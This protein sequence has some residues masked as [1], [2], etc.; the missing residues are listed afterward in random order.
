MIILLIVLLFAA[1]VALDVLWDWRRLTKLSSEGK[2]LHE[3]AGKL[4]P[5][6]VAGF[7]LPPWLSYHKGHTW[8]HWASPD[9]A[10][11]GL[12]DFARRLVGAESNVS[13]P[14][15]GTQV[16]QGEGVIHVKRNGGEAWLL[17]PVGG[18]I[19]EVNPYL[20]KKPDFFFRDSYGQ[21]WI[22]KIRSQHLFQELRNL[23]SGTLAQ[24][25]MEDTR[26]RFR[27][28]LML[29]TGSVIQDGGTPIEDIAS[30]LS[31][32][33]WHTLVQAFLTAKTGHTRE[34]TG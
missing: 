11:V 18:E 24:R 14:A 9:Q 1:L 31:S 17:S 2:A 20:R 30:G 3:A 8:V 27:H 32:E 12:D 29:D 6:S 34:E 26:D 21:G 28:Q 16:T 7:V 13:V 4:E 33:E 5:P 10:Y 15:V 23:L 19:V 22:Y 25:W